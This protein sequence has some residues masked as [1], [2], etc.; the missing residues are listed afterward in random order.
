MMTVRVIEVRRA[1]VT[2]ALSIERLYEDINAAMIRQSSSRRK[3]G[4]AIL[5]ET[6]VCPGMYG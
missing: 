3:T 4:N 6:Y 1:T 5:S 2:G